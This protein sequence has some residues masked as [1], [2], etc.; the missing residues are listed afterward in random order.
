MMP[1]GDLGWGLVV[2]NLYPIYDALMFTL[3]MDMC[4]CV[5]DIFCEFFQQAFYELDHAIP[6]NFNV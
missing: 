1:W 2:Q 3:K 4:C 5:V 6:A